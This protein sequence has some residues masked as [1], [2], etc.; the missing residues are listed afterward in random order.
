MSMLQILAENRRL[1][2]LRG[3]QEAIDYTLNEHSLGTVC[4][5]YGNAAG[6]DILRGDLG[7]LEQHGLIKVERIDA[8]SGK[9]WIAT[10]TTL[11]GEVARGRPWEGVAR[12]GP[13]D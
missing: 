1:I 13:G 7:F 2:V 12:R 9:L 8:E 4:R 10:L 6:K 3:L 5:H 11:G